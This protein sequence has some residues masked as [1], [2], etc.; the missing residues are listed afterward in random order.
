M[1][2]T[3]SL[4]VVGVTAL[5]GAAVSAKRG[6]VDVKTGVLF[7]LPSFTG[8][9]VA[10]HLLLPVLPDTLLTLFGLSLTKPVLVM[11]CFGGLMV[12]ASRAMIR[13]GGVVP[14]K[15]RESQPAVAAPVISIAFK[16]FF[17]GL[18]TGFVGAGGGFLIIPA[19]VLML[20]LPMRVAVGT[21]LAIIAANSLFGFAISA[22]TY[23]ETDWVLLGTICGLGIVGLILGQA[24]S[25]KVPEQVLKRS[26][27]FF[28]M[29]L[30]SLVLLDQV[31]Q[32]F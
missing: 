17:V 15:L 18:T 7:A 2:T 24:W 9:Y 6:H 22:A 8:V 19:L 20:K 25:T 28:V 3:N 1:A 10:R 11:L 14:D 23:G 21:S 13:A 16:G 31:S 30:G 4:F 12:F 32:L 27:G 29:L 5:A 26:F